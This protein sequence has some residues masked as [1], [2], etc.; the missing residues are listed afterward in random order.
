MTK[1]YASSTLQHA[2][3]FD[4]N[5]ISLNK[6]HTFQIHLLNSKATGKKCPKINAICHRFIQVY[7]IRRKGKEDDNDLCLLL[8][9]DLL[10]TES[11]LGFG[12]LQ[13]NNM[14]SSWD[15]DS[16][17]MNKQYDYK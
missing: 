8:K 2:S 16:L 3:Q 9:K 11:M 1:Q 10:P 6:V 7:S 14:F 4:L 12:G 13:R 17:I 5:Y 15:M